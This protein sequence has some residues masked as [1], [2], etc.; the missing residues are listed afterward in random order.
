VAAL[1]LDALERGLEGVEKDNSLE[2]E[3]NGEN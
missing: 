2:E 1:F 3:N